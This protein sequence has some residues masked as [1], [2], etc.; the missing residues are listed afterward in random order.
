MNSTFAETNE[1]IKGMR[2]LELPFLNDIDNKKRRANIQEYLNKTKHI[3]KDKPVLFWAVLNSA[4]NIET[5]SIH[6]HWLDLDDRRRAVRVSVLFDSSRMVVTVMPHVYDK[7]IEL[8][9]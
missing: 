8:K 2:Q 3:S 1:Y 6:R 9:K 7:L 5:M 4:G